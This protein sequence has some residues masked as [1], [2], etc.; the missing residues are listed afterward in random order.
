M[1]VINEIIIHCAAT[2]PEWMANTSVAKQR[3]EIDK[4]HRGNGWAGIGYHYVIGRK[5]DV[6]K[7][8]EDAAVGAHVQGHNANSLGVCLMG[9]HGSN[10]T[11]KF[12]QHYTPEQDLAL[13]TLID[14]LK[15]TYPSITKITGH[16]DYT[17]AKACPGFR[18]NEWLTGHARSV[19]SSTTVQASVVQLASGAGTAAAAVGTLDGTAQVVALVLAGLIMLT[20][21]WIMRERIKK[22][23]SGV[24]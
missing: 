6:A 12:E 16:N 15:K 22:W 2:R 1:R 13:R 4:W 23:V 7:G 11:D 10:S 20:A 8:R 17:N 9:G 24:R 5:G 19:A 14:S 21:L 3:D 18:V